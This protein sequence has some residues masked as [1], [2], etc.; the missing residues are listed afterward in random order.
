MPPFFPLKADLSIKQLGHLR[1]GLGLGLGFFSFLIVSCLL[2]C[3]RVA[4]QLLSHHSVDWTWGKEEWM[5]DLFL[6]SIAYN[7]ALGT[8]LWFW[9]SNFQAKI[10]SRAKRHLRLNLSY[11]VIFSMM[12]I[13]LLLRFFSLIQLFS[14]GTIVELDRS[15][16]WNEYL[17]FILL[18][19]LVLFCIHWNQYKNIFHCNGWILTS[20]AIGIIAIPLMSFVLDIPQKKIN[21][22]I[23]AFYLPQLNY[24]QK[25]IER[26]KQVESQLQ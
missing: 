25:E 1:F 7:H 15:L 10:Q 23:Q 12:A 22:Q 21:Q 6:L 4:Y 17:I 8:T 16:W 5:I 9:F 18:F 26:R 13:W 3:G 24:L 11:N 19:P 20:G 2:I 14:R